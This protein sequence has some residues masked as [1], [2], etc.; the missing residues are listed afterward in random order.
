[1]PGAKNYHVCTQSWKID[2]DPDEC[3]VELMNSVEKL[4]E[5]EHPH[6][7]Y[8][9]KVKYQEHW[10]QIFAYTPAGWLDVVEISILPLGT[11][12]S[13]AKV[14]S[15]STGA[16]PAWLPFGFICDMLLCW[17]PFSDSGMNEFRC[18]ILRE[19]LPFQVTVLY[20]R[21]SDQLLPKNDG[22]DAI[23]YSSPHILETKKI[24]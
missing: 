6:E 1:M 23:G 7:Y 17:C 24:V 9:N 2:N 4:N 8:V 13:L 15:F 22:S 5:T 16:L 11:S 20:E 14:T 10:I 19:S 3:I 21:E 18:K 12:M